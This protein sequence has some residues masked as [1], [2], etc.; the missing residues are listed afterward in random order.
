MQVLLLHHQIT[1]VMKT[2]MIPACLVILL[3]SLSSCSQES[4]TP[5][6]KTSSTT[7]TDAPVTKKRP[8]PY[9]GWY[10]PDN[11]YGFP[12][13]AIDQ[14]KEVPVIR[15]RMPTKEETQS[16]ASLIYVDPEKYPDAK[17]LDIPLPRL[18]KV[19]NEYA[20]REDVII[21]IQALEVGHDSILG[22]RFLNGGNGSARW[23]EVSF[24]YQNELEQYRNGQFVSMEIEIDAFQTKIWKILTDRGYAETLFTA[25][26]LD[27]SIQAAMEKHTHVNFLYSQS[28]PSTAS[29]ANLL[30]G[31]YYIQNDYEEKGYTEKFLLLEDKATD[32]T[33]LKVMCGPYKEDYPQQQK[34]IENWM[35]AVKKWSEDDC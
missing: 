16:E 2:K 24:L 28:G 35:K 7:T 11:L 27:G 29:Y 21:V 30:F 23:N 33:T 9:G 3:I 22:F 6:V 19:Y 10:C 13:V 1:I 31:N 17:P 4:I 15:G 25:L 20:K 5:E 12:A 8:H 32:K 34:R 14:W 26:Q 18:A